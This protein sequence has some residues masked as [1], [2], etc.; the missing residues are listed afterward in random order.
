MLTGISSD[1]VS[2]AEAELDGGDPERVVE[3]ARECGAT[4]VWVHANS[5]LS[6]FG[7]SRRNGYARLR[8]NVLPPGE[9]LPRLANTDY[10]RMLEGVYRGLWGHKQVAADAMPPLGAVV[11]GLYD[12]AEPIGMCRVF[13]KAR[14]IDGPGLLPKARDPGRYARLLLGACALLGPGPADLESWGDAADVVDAYVG[15]GFAVAEQVGGWELRL[16]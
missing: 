12:R 14:L 16:A 9:A 11:L 13:P 6:R 4:L 3:R 10:A 1:G 2:F 15:L 5:D 7:F 8:A